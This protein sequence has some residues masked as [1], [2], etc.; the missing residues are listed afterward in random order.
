MPL[1]DT[2]E[3]AAFLRFH[4]GT[5]EAARRIG[6]S[7]SSL[8][9]IANGQQSGESVRERVTRV[10]AGTRGVVERE[11]RLE[12]VPT[13]GGRFIGNPAIRSQ[14]GSF[15]KVARD[16]GEIWRYINEGNSAFL[17]DNRGRL[18]PIAYIEQND[19]GDWVMYIGDTP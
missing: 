10:E 16:V 5:R 15:R 11:L 14:P 1:T 19:S 3:R 9:R 4:Y 6:V 17:I 13:R 2:Q 8:R 18:R 7:E 12:G